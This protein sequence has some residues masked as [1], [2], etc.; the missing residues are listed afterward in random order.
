[1]NA[2]GADRAQKVQ[3][4]WDPFEP[5]ASAFFDKNDKFMHPPEVNSPKLLW[6]FEMR[7]AMTFGEVVVLVRI[8]GSGKAKELFVF[9][10]TDRLFTRS[11][12]RALGEARWKIEGDSAWFYYK[13]VFNEK[14]LEAN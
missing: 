4:H 9:S 12:I 7:R 5:P 6:P 2:F 3:I 14:V 1:M 10:S 11:T 13:A 8:D